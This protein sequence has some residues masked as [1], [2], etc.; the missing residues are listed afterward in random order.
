MRIRLIT[1]GSKM[2]GWVEEGYTEYSRRL[3]ADLKLELVEIPLNR[4]SKGADVNRLQEKEANQMLAAVGQGDLVVTMEIKGKA[5]STEQLAD[6]MGEWMHSGRNVSLLVGGPEG[7]HPSCMAQADL[8]WSL[9]PLTLPH[10]LVRVVVAEQVYRA[11]SILK[12][13]PYH[14]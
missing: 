3:G 9:S 8:R 2:P 10:P 12:N 5:W 7:L 14:K 4:R 6:K 11:W 13:H 1:V